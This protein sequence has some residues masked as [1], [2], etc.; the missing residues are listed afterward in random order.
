MESTSIQ[1]E[2]EDPR[3]ALAVADKALRRLTDGLRLPAGLFPLLAAAVALQLATA[4]YGIAAQTVTGLV[5]VLVGLAAFLGTAALLL[6]R[7][8]RINGVRVDGLVSH[9]VLAAGASDSLIYLGAFAAGVW[10]A[11]ASLWWL[12]AAAAVAG[13][14][15]CALGAQ[16][17]WHT[18]RSN[19]AAHARGV[20]PRMLGVL[21]VLA[22]LGIAGLVVFG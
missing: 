1:Q 12:V 16:H 15:G 11:F 13:G 3:E 7:F 6:H 8:R 22:C 20:S 17:W 14:I 5:V 9:V 18:Y 4:A 10:A 2:P 19:P 21:A